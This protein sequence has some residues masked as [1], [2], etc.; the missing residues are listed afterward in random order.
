MLSI[1]TMILTGCTYSD[2]SSEVQAVK[3][4]F[5]PLHD[6]VLIGDSYFNLGLSRTMICLGLAFPFIALGGVFYK[7]FFTKQ[8]SNEEF[9]NNLRFGAGFLWILFMAF[10]IDLCQA[11]GW[12]IMIGAA[13]IMAF[14]FY[15]S[16]D[17]RYNIASALLYLLVL[18]ILLIIINN[19]QIF[20]PLFSS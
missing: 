9:E 14:T 5:H 4:G 8:Y 19:G 11:F 6:V 3:E 7:T 20:K 16:R 17:Y 12:Y 1:M 18:V 13:A 10:S 15:K 2:T